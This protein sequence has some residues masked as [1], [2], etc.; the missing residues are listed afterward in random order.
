MIMRATK[1]IVKEVM[2]IKVVLCEA[3]NSEEAIREDYWKK[4]MKMRLRKIKR[5]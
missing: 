3:R 1:E 5:K 2:F 4:S